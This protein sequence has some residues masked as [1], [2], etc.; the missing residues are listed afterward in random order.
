MQ[1]KQKFFTWILSGIA[2]FMFISFFLPIVQYS[3]S[4]WGVTMKATMSPLNIL[5]DKVKM[6]AAGSSETTKAGIS[7]AS[8]FPAILFL[9]AVLAVAGLMVWYF[10]GGNKKLISLCVAGGSAL[11]LICL[12][13]MGFSIKIEGVK[14]KPNALL[15]ILVILVI[16]QGVVAFLN[17]QNEGGPAPAA[18]VQYS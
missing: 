4:M 8:K 9:L 3:E 17:S 7:A 10:L 2:A 16:G 11:E 15:W 12:F 18:P 13:W 6:S 14:M 5:M 1:D